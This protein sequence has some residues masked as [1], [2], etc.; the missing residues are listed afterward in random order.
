MKIPGNGLCSMTPDPPS[1]NSMIDLQFGWGTERDF[2]SIRKILA[3]TTL[4]RYGILPRSEHANSY[5]E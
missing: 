2:G 4:A 5:S 1:V 3:L